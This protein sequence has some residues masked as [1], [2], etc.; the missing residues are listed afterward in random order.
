MYVTAAATGSVKRIE[1]T[2]CPQCIMKK[3]STRGGID[4]GAAPVFCPKRFGGVSIGKM[5]NEKERNMQ[6][7]MHIKRT[8]SFDFKQGEFS[9]QSM[10]Y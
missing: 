7:I 4:P 6:T 5:T 9:L 2:L 3:L 1:G 8:V 10:Q